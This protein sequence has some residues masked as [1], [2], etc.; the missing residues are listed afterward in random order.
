MANHGEMVTFIWGVADLIRDS[1]KR[2]HYQDVILP[3]T[4]LRRIDSVLAPTRQKVF[5]THSKLK[6]KLDNLDP[7][8][9]KASGFAFY[10]TSKYTFE[11]LVK[12]PQ[13]LAANLRAY[14][15]GFSKNMGDVIEKFDFPNTIAKL[16]T[17][18][19]LFRVVERFAEADL[20]PG[21][22]SN[23]EMGYVFEELI[24]K[25]NEALDENPGEH[26]TPREVIR[27]MVNLMT[28]H[29][30]SALQTGKVIRTVYDPCCGSGGMLTIAK[31]R[32]QAVNPAADVHLF[33]QEVNPAT[34]AVCKSDLYI[35]SADGRDADNIAFGSVLSQDGH[36]ERTFDYQL[37]NPPYGK[38][39]NLDQD[40]VRAEAARA[41][42]NRFEAGLPRINDGQLLFLQHM[43]GRM[44]HPS[45]GASR[46][47]IIMNGSPLFT[48]D[49]GSGE[50]EIR[51]WIL[52][53]D[54][55]EAL[56]ALPKDLFY[57]T[58]ISTYVWVLGNTKPT[59]RRGNV[60]LIDAS[61]AWLPRRKSLG[62]KR[63]DI[64]DGVERTEN[65]IPLIVKL[66]EDFTDGT[67]AIPADEPKT[68]RSKI[69]PTSAFGYRKV[70]IERPLRLNFQASRERLARVE[71]TKAFQNLTASKKKRQEE[72]D[73]DE[74]VGRETQSAIRTMLEYLPDDLI[75]DRAEFLPLFHAAA[76]RA[77]LRLP[78][79]LKRA[80]L[81]ALSERD[82]SAAICKDE[83]GNPE[84]DPELRDTEN[85][86]LGESVPEF[87]ER[88]VKPHVPDAWINEDIRDEKDG[89]IGLVGYE[90]NFNRYFY[91]YQ[92]PRPLEEIEADI[93]AVE[94]DVLRLLKEVAA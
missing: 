66:F 22:L 28:S 4:V 47:S 83:E 78:A 94:A 2:G 64:P 44:R 41:A 32:I 16:E 74:A 79:P 58:G 60:Q 56:I 85:V 80:I 55:L 25:F 91:Q 45:E 51:R 81:D 35:K 15:A 53:N 48:G 71:E 20:S 24:R 86:P 50:S 59:G 11:T 68:L 87:F 82:E 69:F 75:T 1:F 39:W 26:F 17:A 65:Y 30:R 37:A 77:G 42:K 12:E 19:L 54:Y 6:G 21:R 23:H 9:C 36:A 27:L 18:N 13:Q 38:D 52:E 34:F 10:N 31:E 89:E 76:R 7:Q 70:T 73:A 14:L 40:T 61:E 3:F 29:D 63:R 92:P 57:N 49:A 88:E 72:R 90:I 43:L 84:A 8:L 93:K 5:E 46:V 62:N 33:G 67:A